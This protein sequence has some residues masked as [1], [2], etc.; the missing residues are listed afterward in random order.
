MGSCSHSAT[1]SV[2]ETPISGRINRTC[3]LDASAY[4]MV[5][6]IEC[7]LGGGII[8]ALMCLK[9]VVGMHV[10]LVIKKIQKN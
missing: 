2:H 8:H 6:H 9:V 1:G 7:L 5:V 4:Y 10:C 3:P